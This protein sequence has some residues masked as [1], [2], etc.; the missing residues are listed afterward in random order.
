MSKRELTQISPLPAVSLLVRA[1]LLGSFS[2]QPLLHSLLD[3]H[4]AP[5]EGPSGDLW[6]L[7]ALPSSAVFL[8]GC[9]LSFHP[10]KAPSPPACSVS[11][12]LQQIQ[13]LLPLPSM[14]EQYS[15]TW[16]ATAQRKNQQPSSLLHSVSLV[17]D[18]NAGQ[19]EKYNSVPIP[20]KPLGHLLQ[21]T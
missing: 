18:H 20:A 16:H 6:C 19:R 4:V 15:L 5:W 11:S 10:P 2:A 8:W 9:Q 13:L 17:K 3:G 14:K 12:F 1:T 21:K 7:A